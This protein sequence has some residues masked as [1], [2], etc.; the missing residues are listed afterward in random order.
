MNFKYKLSPKVLDFIKGAN[1]EEISIGCS[2]SQVFK[3]IKNNKIY[4]I[5][6]AN[7]GNLTSEYEKLKWLAGKL[8]VPKIILYD[9]TN[10][11][12]YLITESVGGEMVCSKYY[13]Q[14]PEIGLKVIA[15]AFK[16]IYK[17][18]IKDCP[19]NV[20][21]DYKLALVENNV[22]NNLIK[23][24]EISEDVLKRFGSVDNILK[25]LRENKFTSELCFSHGDTSLPN[26]FAIKDKFSG[27]IDVGECGIADKW[28]DLAICEKSIRRNYGEE[29]IAKFYEELKIVPERDKIDYYLL[30]MELYL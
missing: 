12:E 16:Q 27:F 22:K 5:K 20:D 6:I 23:V 3:I 10:D 18:D 11:T 13:L 30:M 25:F 2:D 26:I 15:K 8:S 21:I 9:W 14:N 29:Y 17:I 24:D 7:K 1:L 4:F 28:F 19:F